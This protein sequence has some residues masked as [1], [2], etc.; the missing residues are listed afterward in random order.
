[1]EKENLDVLLDLQGHVPAARPG[2]LAAVGGG[3]W[4]RLA[5]PASWAATAAAGEERG[6]GGPHGLL[7]DLI[8][9]PQDGSGD[10][11][12]ALH[13]L[14]T[15]WPWGWAEG[16]AEAELDLPGRLR[17]RAAHGVSPALMDTWVQAAR[18]LSQT[19]QAEAGGEAASELRIVE[20]L[21]EARPQLRNESHA[22]GESQLAFEVGTS[23]PPAAVQGPAAAV[24]M[25]SN[26]ECATPKLAALRRALLRPGA[27]APAVVLPGRGMC[28]RAAATTA[29][30]LGHGFAP[31]VASYKEYEDHAVALASGPPPAAPRWR[32]GATGA[33]P[34][35]W[36]R[37]ARAVGG[38]VAQWATEAEALYRGGPGSAG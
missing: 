38:A 35:R 37:G 7:A 20:V 19:E 10:Y 5:L 1:L 2:L 11:A 36:A 29:V 30:A 31:L 24:I 28:A 17:G 23:A 16:E 22:R 13:Y 8:S 4:W 3:E 12:E 21:E 32:D 34:P 15:P 18:R 6:G 9:V 33:P 25:E 27:R 26:E 14:D